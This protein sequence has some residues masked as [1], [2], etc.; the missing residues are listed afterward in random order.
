MHIHYRIDDN[1]DTSR[2]GTWFSCVDKASGYRHVE[3]SE[4][5]KH[6]TAFSTH[7]GL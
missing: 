3:V 7:K 6:K 4:Q 2:G 5:D 1:V